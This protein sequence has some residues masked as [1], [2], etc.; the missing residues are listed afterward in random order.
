MSRQWHSTK[1]NPFR[2][3]WFM[4]GWSTTV[5]VTEVSRKEV[6]DLNTQNGLS[7]RQHP[8]T[9]RKV[10]KFCPLEFLRVAMR[11]IQA[12]VLRHWCVWYQRRKSI[13][14]LHSGQE[15]E[16]I[17]SSAIRS[18]WT[19]CPNWYISFLFFFLMYSAFF[20]GMNQVLLFS[21]MSVSD[22]SRSVL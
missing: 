13:I 3:R 15:R 16:R 19:N 4:N 20:Y 8:V 22:I 10:H 9:D 14:T 5:L 17:T 11:W 7:R 12:S 2:S 1:W 18:S 21:S 6:Y